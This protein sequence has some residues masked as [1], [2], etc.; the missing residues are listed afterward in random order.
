MSFGGGFFCQGSKMV[1]VGF[2]VLFLGLALLF[3]VLPQGLCA[4]PAI[5]PTTACVALVASQVQTISTI[6]SE[7]SEASPRTNAPAPSLFSTSKI[8]SPSLEENGHVGIGTSSP[9]EVLDVGGNI[10]L[11]TI[12]GSA[13]NAYVKF[14]NSGGNY[15]YGG[16]GNLMAFNTASGERMRITNTGNVGIGFTSPFFAL[17]V[18]SIVEAAPPVFRDSSWQAKRHQNRA[19]DMATTAAARD[20]DYRSRASPDRKAA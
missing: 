6:Q 7:K 15:I 8:A 16:D 12:P 20:L 3:S 5:M 10:R 17:P 2:I 11:N 14:G 4:S 18:A 9:T 19:H 1:L 13:G